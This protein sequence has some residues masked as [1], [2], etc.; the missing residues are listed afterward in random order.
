MFYINSSGV[1]TELNHENGGDVQ[2][3]SINIDSDGLHV[4]VNH[5]NH[6]MYFENNLV[7]L[8]GVQSDIKPTKL[9]SSYEIGSVGSISIE[10]STNFTVL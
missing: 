1:L 6:G 9:S 8:S 10:D 5:K 2:I 4:K 3:S 7:I